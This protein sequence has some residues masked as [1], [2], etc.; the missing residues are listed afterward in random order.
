MKLCNNLRLIGAVGLA[1]GVA[2][3]GPAQGQPATKDSAA[4]GSEHH[5]L[6]KVEGKKAAVYLLGSIHVLK[7]E[8]YP[9][10]EPIEKAFTNSEVVAFET[11][12]AALEDPA[13]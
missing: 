10:A 1:I 11:D 2:F 4:K 5:S 12:V 9:L 13:L 3:S 8:D 7:E 6:W